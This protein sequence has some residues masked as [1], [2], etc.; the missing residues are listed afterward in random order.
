MATVAVT[1]IKNGRTDSF[2][3]PLIAGTY[4]PAVEINTANALWNAGYVSVADASVFDQDP[5]AGTNPLDDFNVA[6]SIAI[7][8]QP[9]E[10][11]ANLAAELASIG[12]G[13]TDEQIIAA[14]PDRREAGITV[15]AA[16]GRYGLTFSGG[17]NAPTLSDNNSGLLITT[18][19][20]TWADVTFPQL[21]AARLFPDQWTMEVYS[22]DWSAIS[23]FTMYIGSVSNFATSWTRVFSANNSDK[24]G[25][26]AMVGAGVRYLHSDFAAHETLGSPDKATTQIQ[27]HKLRITPMAGRSAT[28]QIRKI[29]YDIIDVPS[30]SLTF[31]DG[32]QTVIDNA[33]PVMIARGLHG[34][35]CIIPGKIGTDAR[36]ASVASW[37]SQW[38]ANGNECIGHG[39]NFSENN[40]TEAGTIAGAVADM[41]F[42]RSFMIANSLGTEGSENIYC[43]PQGIYTF[44]ADKRDISLRAAAF[45]AGYLGARGVEFSYMN[46]AVVGH[47][48]KS[49]VTPIIGWV[50]NTGGDEPTNIT[51]LLAKIDAICDSKK[52]GTLMFHAVADSIDHVNNISIEN[53]TT[54]MDRIALRVAQG[55]LIN[56]LFS[57]Q[58]KWA[59]E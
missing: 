11:A 38:I 15:Y 43:W 33:L 42:G 49:M 40:L 50:K 57:Q 3:R 34:S 24:S 53:F 55:R 7:S 2:G 51:T 29:K 22:P 25:E 36:F 16:T 26:P 47:Y 12:R 13:A 21:S 58:I 18:P 52:S 39:P 35:A 48:P 5:L 32:Y 37:V 6:R 19:S 46:S 1:C 41:D 45:A 14:E 27:Y 4:Y 56:P 10:T 30:L 31:D 8:R 20:G 54:L 9:I 23:S 17:A 59:A 44:L 28:V